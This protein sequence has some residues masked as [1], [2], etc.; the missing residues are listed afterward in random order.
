MNKDEKFRMIKQQ[1][2]GLTLED[3][4]RAVEAL[5]LGIKLN[6]AGTPSADTIPPLSRADRTIQSYSVDGVESFVGTGTNGYHTDLPLGEF[7]DPIPTHF[8]RRRRSGL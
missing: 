2:M 8:P 4:P 7:R 1:A 5:C 3:L 6:G